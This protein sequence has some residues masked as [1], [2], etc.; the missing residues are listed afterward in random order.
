MP[1]AASYSA[2][3]RRQDILKLDAYIWGD[4]E[5]EN[6]GRPCHA[7][8]CWGRNSV[9]MLAIPQQDVEELI[10]EHVTRISWRIAE[11]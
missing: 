5:D 8:C 10:P 6:N 9:G 3:C 1:R 4:T 11:C 2:E 7:Y